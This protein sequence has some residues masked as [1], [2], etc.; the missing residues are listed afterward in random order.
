MKLTFKLQEIENLKKCVITN[1]PYSARKP[2]GRV[3]QISSC[4]GLVVRQ[5]ISGDY[6]R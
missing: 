1:S 3:R 4:F 5:G 2:E 6:N